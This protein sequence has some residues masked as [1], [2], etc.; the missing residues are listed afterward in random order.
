[1]TTRIAFDTW[2]MAS[3]F[4]NQGIYVYT[5]QL[6]R[7]FRE[8]AEECS[9]EIR[10][11]ISAGMSNDA[12]ALQ[13]GRGFLPVETRLMRFDR[14]WR[15]GGASVS[16]FMNQADLIF[17][18][19]GTF[20]PVP[21]L[22]PTFSTIHDATPVIM[23]AWYG[24]T[25][26]AMRFF[27]R[28]NAQRSQAVIT[29]SLCSKR[30]LLEAFQ[31]PDSKVSVV[32]LGYDKA[33]FNDD[34]ADLQAQQNL[35]LKLGLKKPY[36]FHHGTIQ[37]RKNL[38]RLIEAFRLLM[39]RNCNLD[40]DLVLAG[41]LGWQYED[42][43]TAVEENSGSVARVV[44]AGAVSDA[45]VALLLKAAS[46]TVI[47]SLY[48]GFCLPM[49]ESMASGTPTIAA[50]TSCLPEVSGG[51]LKYFNPEEVEDIASCMESALEDTT[52]RQE[53]CRRGKERALSFDWRRCAQETLSILSSCN[54]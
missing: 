10:P 53:L 13:A 38:A 24:R 52:L 20:L 48:E 1:M 22:L 4:R 43:L 28:R 44:L 18:P 9:V 16:A 11:F 17:N 26:C 5:R 35:F 39:S 47:P 29:D 51:V 36:V 12:N 19:S 21:S 15:I 42:V 33:T 8:M 14:L 45:E 25:S 7:Y 49:I 32:Y 27:L 50:N 46:L 31:L 37:P 40:F 54:S 23:P 6:L 3:R 34:A 2:S 30:D 41:T